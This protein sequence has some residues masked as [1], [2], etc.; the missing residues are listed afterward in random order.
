MATE[1]GATT[2]VSTIV[3]IRSSTIVLSGLTTVLKSATGLTIDGVSY[4]ATGATTLT[5]S[6]YSHTTVSKST[7]KSTRTIISSVTAAA[8][9]VEASTSSTTDASLTA[10]STA[11]IAESATPSVSSSAVPQ[12]DGLPT[13][14]KIIIATAVI[15]VLTLL[16]LMAFFIIRWR[17]KN[18]R[19]RQG[20]GNPRLLSTSRDV[21]T[22]STTYSRC[23]TPDSMWKGY[24]TDERYMPATKPAPTWSRSLPVPVAPNDRL[25]LNHTAPPS[26]FSPFMPRVSNSSQPWSRNPCPFEMSSEEA[27]MMFDVA[28]PQSQQNQ[29]QQNNSRRTPERINV[30][31][32]MSS[33]EAQMIIER[34]PVSPP[35][36]SPPTPQ[37]FYS[38]PPDT[39]LFPPQYQAA[40][41]RSRPFQAE[42]SRHETFYNATTSQP[43]AERDDDMM[44]VKEPKVRWVDKLDILRGRQGEGT[45]GP[46]R[47][48]RYSWEG[49][50]G[51]TY[52][53]GE[54]LD[55]RKR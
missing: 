34:T 8:L 47:E 42:E 45:R 29:S 24:A 36:Q 2:V 15:I 38:P 4:L 20:G 25:F 52:H 19:I 55:T 54:I 32:D 44:D 3:S 27:A 13:P 14:T 11:A 10:S 23:S 6:N 49:D 26:D 37:P 7:S 33:D 5:I 1:S 53:G 39:P 41:E 31:Q 50:E 12:S 28:N 17:R 16:G 18:Q 21:D 9:A 35:I 51:D 30:S 48:R 46:S 40:T 43:P 22:T